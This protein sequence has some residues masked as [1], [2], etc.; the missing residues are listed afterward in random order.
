MNIGIDIDC[1]CNNLVEEWLFR[2]NNKYNLNVKYDDI[3]SY[4]I[5]QFFPTLSQEQ[6][7]EPLNDN[8]MWN[9][10]VPRQDSIKYIKQLQDDGHE[11]KLITATDVHFMPVKCKWILKHYPFINE[12]DIWM[13]FDK[14]WIK[15][16]ILLDDCVANLQGSSYL[17]ICYSQPWNTAYKGLR[18][19]NWKEFYNIILKAPTN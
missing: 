12:K 5:S 3:T 8:D 2:L 17:G 19:N 15:A 1:V 6:I 16:D 14:T 18:V 11:I 10:L 7:Y 4:S 9:S 13:V